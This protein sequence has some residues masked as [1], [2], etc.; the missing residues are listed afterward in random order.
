MQFSSSTCQLGIG[1][2][3]IAVEAVQINGRNMEHD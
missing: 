1:N 3:F 2:I